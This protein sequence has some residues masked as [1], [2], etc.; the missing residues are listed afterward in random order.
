MPKL[1]GVDAGLAEN[2]IETAIP[3]RH[4]VWPSSDI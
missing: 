4:M 3:N 1:S 2:N